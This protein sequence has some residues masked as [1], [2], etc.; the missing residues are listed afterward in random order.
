MCKNGLLVTLV[1]IGHFVDVNQIFQAIF[2]EFVNDIKQLL[3][4]V[5]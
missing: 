4:E 2:I 1:I 3:N 5:E